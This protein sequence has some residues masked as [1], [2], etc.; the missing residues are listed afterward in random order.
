MPTIVSNSSPLIHLAKIDQLHLLHDFFDQIIIPNAVY[1]ECVIEDKEYQEISRIK[2]ADWL[3]TCHVSDRNLVIL[4]QSEIDKGESEAI[5]LAL[6]KSAHLIL[7]DDA[8]AREKARLYH[9][10]ITG[11]IGILLR[12]KKEGKLQSFHQVINQLQTTG[13]W[14]NEKLKQR[15]LVEVG[16]NE[17]FM[18]S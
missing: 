12:A 7:L 3:Q 18:L 1:N 15:L 4:L 2:N 11:T 10:K 16:E 5:A 9:L 17:N 14:L 6:E 13:F 8:E